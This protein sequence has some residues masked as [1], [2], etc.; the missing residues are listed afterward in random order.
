MNGMDSPCGIVT[1]ALQ[2]GAANQ[3]PGP[4][5]GTGTDGRPIYFKASTN[6]PGSYYA[7]S[8]PGSVFYNLRAAGIAASLY[9]LNKSSND[10]DDREFAGE[11]YEDA[12]GIYSYDEPRP[13]S[14]GHSEVDPSAIPAQTVFVADY[15]SHGSF[16]A[17]GT[18]LFSPDDKFGIVQY[19]FIFDYYRGGYLGTP[20]GYVK[21]FNPADTETYTV[22]KPPL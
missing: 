9:A 21:F 1:S 5:F 12:N 7:Y 16:P 14:D 19:W 20:L 8:G 22:Y 10:S 6:G 11:L 17:P 15:H 18:E 3:C 4:C 2:G 13:G